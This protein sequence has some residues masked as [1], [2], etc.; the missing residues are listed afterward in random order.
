M[1]VKHLVTISP[2][3]YEQLFCTKGF[4]QLLRAYNLGM[5]FLQKDFDA[6]AAHKC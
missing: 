4:V 2:I 3:F 5:Y 1:L 6:K